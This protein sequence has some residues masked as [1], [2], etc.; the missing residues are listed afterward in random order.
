MDLSFVGKNLYKA[1]YS[2]KKNLKKG[3]KHP[4]ESYVFAIDHSLDDDGLLRVIAER[5]GIYIANEEDAAVALYLKLKEYL[6]TETD[7]EKTA[8]LLNVSYEDY[9]N[10]YGNRLLS[11]K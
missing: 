8:R 5:I 4:L 2:G 3:E 10:T 9:P 11:E 7:V 1:L 6:E